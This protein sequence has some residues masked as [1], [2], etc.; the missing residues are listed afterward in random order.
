MSEKIWQKAAQLI[1]KASGDPLLQPNE[2]LIEIV[3]TLLNEEQ[4]K[5][6][7]Y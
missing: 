2:T 7:F 6:I 5:K 4:D 1:A 3:K